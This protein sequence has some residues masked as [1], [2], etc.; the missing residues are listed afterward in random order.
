MRGDPD[1]NND[2]K[3]YCISHTLPAKCSTFLVSHA[4]AG[5]NHCVLYIY[6]LHEYIFKNS[7]MPVIPMA[8]EFV[9]QLL[10]DHCSSSPAKPDIFFFPSSDHF[11]LILLFHHENTLLT[12]SRQDCTN[13]I[14][15]HLGRKKSDMQYFLQTALFSQV[16]LTGSTPPENVY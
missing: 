8:L 13:Y 5:R 2:R 4:R 3:K 15:L 12:S 6:S 16:F 7:Y 1:E 11:K 9:T 10:T 14:V